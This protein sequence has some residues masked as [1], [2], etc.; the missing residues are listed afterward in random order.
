MP[1]DIPTVTAQ[2]S[3]KAAEKAIQQHGLGKYA[4]I[5]NVGA[6]TIICV[7]FVKQQMENRDLLHSY[8]EQVTAERKSGDERF[9]RL[10]ERQDKRNERQW[11][12]MSKLA[13][14]LNQINLNLIQVLSWLRMPQADRVGLSVP[15]PK[16][17][18]V[19]PPPQE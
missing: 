6:M 4:W 12:N 18:E 19:R 2:L 7:L 9:A 15:Q 3:G 11:Q 1:D 8:Q 17:V 10:E 5:G 13:D 16:A 14:G